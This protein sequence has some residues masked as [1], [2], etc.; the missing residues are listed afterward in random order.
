L[1]HGDVGGEV[2]MNMA[3]DRRHVVWKID[4]GSGDEKGHEAE[5]E[6]IWRK[7]IRAIRREWVKTEA[8]QLRNQAED[9]LRMNFSVGVSMYKAKVTSYW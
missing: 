1:D 4:V 2:V 9:S 5:N 8:S 3:V 6:E 7:C